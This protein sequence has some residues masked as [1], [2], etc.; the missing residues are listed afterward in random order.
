MIKMESKQYKQR[1]I[2][3]FF[4]IS[5][6]YLILMTE[7]LYSNEISDI[8][9]GELLIWK[10]DAK[11]WYKNLYYYCQWPKEKPQELLL[12]RKGIPYSYETLIN[13]V[14]R[15][16]VLDKDWAKNV[17][18]MKEWIP[19]NEPDIKLDAYLYRQ[20]FEGGTL[21]IC[22]TRG[23][24][25]IAYSTNKEINLSENPRKLI[26]II[27]SK[28]FIMDFPK[29]LNNV[30]FKL[31]DN[32]A[33]FYG[34]GYGSERPSIVKL[35]DKLEEKPA[36][37][38]VSFVGER[39]FIFRFDKLYVPGSETRLRINDKQEIFQLFGETPKEYAIANKALE[40]LEK[41]KEPDPNNIP[42]V[43]KIVK[44]IFE[45]STTIKYNDNQY[46]YKLIIDSKIKS[47]NYILLSI[48]SIKKGSDKEVELIKKALEIEKYLQNPDENPE[49]GN[50]LK[51]KRA[52]IDALYRIRTD[53]AAIA[54]LEIIEGA[55]EQD[56]Q[57][58]L[59]ALELYPLFRNR[60]ESIYEKE[61]QKTGGRP[62][63][64]YIIY[65]IFVEDL[66][67]NPIP[68]VTFSFQKPK[69]DWLIW[70]ILGGLAFL[71]VIIIAIQK[72]RKTKQSS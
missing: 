38:I 64:N 20:I 62:V 52:A 36:F 60:I 28:L 35:G 18:R 8:N 9:R 14:M 15:P 10:T 50:L 40:E 24:T 11:P 56:R 65:K 39:A 71:I 30:H 19:S 23:T 22:D 45:G 51:L 63:D 58:L 68:G 31:E 48:E 6:M 57:A 61:K 41:F 59:G 17:L 66:K 4:L 33:V 1:I 47:M 32:I 72:N 54:H 13:H 44:N 69:Y 2:W 21:H 3:L 55:K 29:D 26:N 16:G 12:E 46:L 49:R 37:D 7:I 25:V 67:K 42:S 27:F 34:F 5:S 53:E 43:I 70:A